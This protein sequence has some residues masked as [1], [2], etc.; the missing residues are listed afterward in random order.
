TERGNI[1]MYQISFI[2]IY[3][4]KSETFRNTKQQA[5]KLAEAYQNIGC[6]EVIVSRV[7]DEERVTDAM[8]L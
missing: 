4:A 7:S 2:N 6:T 1:V 3:G 8:A 5:E